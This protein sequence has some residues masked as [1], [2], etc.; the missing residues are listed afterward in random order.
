MADGANAALTPSHTAVGS[1]P[2]HQKPQNTPDGPVITSG[3]QRCV[4]RFRV[5]QKQKQAAIPSKLSP[6]YGEQPLSR[7]TVYDWHKELPEGRD[8]VTNKPNA[9][10]KP[11]AVRC[12]HSSRRGLDFGK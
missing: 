9:H 10:V 5:K 11:T 6:Q 3:E 12:V 1:A 7:A 8:Q 2:A 4:I